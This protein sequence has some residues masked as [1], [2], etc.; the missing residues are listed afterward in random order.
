MSIVVPL[1]ARLGETLVFVL[2]DMCQQLKSLPEQQL[3]ILSLLLVKLAE[4]ALFACVLT[5]VLTS[6]VSVVHL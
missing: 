5:R 2:A 4:R 1:I 6:V 3:L